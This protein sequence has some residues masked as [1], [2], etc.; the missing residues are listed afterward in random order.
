MA[1]PSADFDP[2]EITG[3]HLSFLPYTS[4]STGQAQ[5][6]SSLTHEGQLWWVRC[7]FSATGRRHPDTAASLAA[8]P[9][10]H[11]NAMA[12]AIKPMLNM[13]AD[14]WCMLPNFEPRTLHPQTLSDY[15][16]HQARAAC[17]QSFSHDAAV[18]RDLIESLDFSELEA[19]VH[20][21]GAGEQKNWRTRSRKPSVCTVT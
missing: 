11:K 10:Y 15:K 21:V 12:G 1:T 17:R 18:I 16:M 3:D 19:L 13:P 5:R 9:L 6:V 2:P 4:G 8:M 7:L 20:R 14:R